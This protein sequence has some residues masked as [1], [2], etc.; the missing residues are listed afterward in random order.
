MSLHV[1]TDFAVWIAAA[2]TL[3]VFSFLYKDNP[4]Y[5]FAEHLFVGVSAGY[6]IVLNY[7]T[8]IVANLYDPL[9]KAFAGVDRDAARR[10]FLR[11][12]DAPG[13]CSRPI[14]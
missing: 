4:L 5:K 6:Y 14:G 12:R 8:V 10:R 1:S 9:M 13:G 2:L 11:R 7:W 3:F